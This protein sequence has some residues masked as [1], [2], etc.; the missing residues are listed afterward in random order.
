MFQVSMLALTVIFG[1]SASNSSDTAN[2]PS[3]YLLQVSSNLNCQTLEIDVMSDHGTGD[4]KL[5]FGQGAFAAVDLAH[6]EHML[7]TVTCHDSPLGT[8]TFEIL[9]DSVAPFQLEPG[10]AYFGGKLILMEES[11]GPDSTAPDV[12]ENC[13]R[14]ISRARGPENTNCRDGVGVDTALRGARFVT[15]YA[16]TL[17]AAELQGIRSALSMTDAQLVYLPLSQL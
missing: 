12:L 14:R 7:G 1:A 11:Q 5:T 2:A 8:R 10:Q 3:T 9:K 17:D 16:P 13:V 15:V 6:G 4:A